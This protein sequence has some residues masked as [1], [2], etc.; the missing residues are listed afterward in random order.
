MIAKN[1]TE[2]N[3]RQILKNLGEDPSREGLI[4]TPGRVAASFE[5]LTSGYRDEKIIIEDCKKAIFKENVRSAVAVKDIEFYSLC[6]HHLL[7]FWGK[8]SIGF[9]PHR[10]GAI[11]GLSKFARI[12]D[13][14]SRRLQVQERLGQDIMEASIKILRPQAISITIKA[15]HM[16]MMMRGVEKHESST[17]TYLFEGN[18]KLEQT[19]DRIK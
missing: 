18:K 9:I 11:L 1:T 6:E 15:Q 19:L 3:I 16:C 5:F 17:Q 4:L 14:Y 7:P 2:N 8:V 12:V 13:L 10:S